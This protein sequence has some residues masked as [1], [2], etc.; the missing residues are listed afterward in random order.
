MNILVS[1][2]GVRLYVTS[3]TQKYLHNVT[4]FAT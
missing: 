1:E 3:T 4:F 2:E